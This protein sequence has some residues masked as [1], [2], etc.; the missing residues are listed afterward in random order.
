MNKCPICGKSA[1]RK[2]CSNACRQRNHRN[3]TKGL[4]LEEAFENLNWY[5]ENEPKVIMS[6][7]NVAEFLILIYTMQDRKQARKL[8]NGTWELV[9]STPIEP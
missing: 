3:V 7:P 5:L 8:D 1:R 9:S 6:A 4:S 2:F